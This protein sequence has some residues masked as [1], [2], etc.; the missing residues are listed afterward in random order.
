MTQVPEQT[1]ATR[2]IRPAGWAVWFTVAVGLGFAVLELAVAVFATNWDSVADDLVRLF[3]IVAAVG[4]GVM[5]VTTL[6]DALSKRPIVVISA[7]GVTWGS[8]RPG[9]PTLRWQEI[10][11]I[12]R[13]VR[14]SG[15]A[16]QRFLLRPTPGAEPMAGLSLGSRIRL[17]LNRLSFGAPFGISTMGAD[18][19]AKE[20]D[21]ILRQH[22]H[23][24]WT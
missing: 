4:F 5:G 17:F 12:R 16:D 11:E 8:R 2:T 23:G 19:S 3:F 15:M 21:A 1:P 24:R 14:M 10:A 22:F 18:I 7:E 6:R 13:R 9:N 20:L